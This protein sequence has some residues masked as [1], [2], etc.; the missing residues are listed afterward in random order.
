M[1]MSEKPEISLRQTLAVTISL[2][3]SIKIYHFRFPVVVGLIVSFFFSNLY[4]VSFI[5][6][7]LI[8]TVINSVYY[9]YTVEFYAVL[10]CALCL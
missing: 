4:N 1:L 5:N 7:N 2:Q 9:I 8:G 6:L 3:F 10:H